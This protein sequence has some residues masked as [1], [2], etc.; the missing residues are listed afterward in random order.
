VVAS[1]H[2]AATHVERDHPQWGKLGPSAPDR[3]AGGYC[4]DG[5]GQPFEI[6]MGLLADGRVNTAFPN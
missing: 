3:D 4:V 2:Y 6:R 5:N 1:I